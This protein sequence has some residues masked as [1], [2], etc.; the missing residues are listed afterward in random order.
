MEFLGDLTDDED[1]LEYADLVLRPRIPRVFRA[2]TLHFDKWSEIEFKERFRLSKN[3][4][5]YVV[6]LIEENIVSVTNW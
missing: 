5:K 2:R 4:V 1:F 3:T 6:D